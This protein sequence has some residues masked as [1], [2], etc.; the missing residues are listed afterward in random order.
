MYNV[1]RKQLDAEIQVRKVGRSSSSDLPRK[2]NIEQNL[3]CQENSFFTNTA[4]VDDSLGPV[5]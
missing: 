2:R 3:L 5:V 4:R 1:I